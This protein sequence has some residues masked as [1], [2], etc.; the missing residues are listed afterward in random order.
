MA[1]SCGQTLSEGNVSAFAKTSGQ[2]ALVLDL[3]LDLVLEL[4]LVLDLVLELALVLD[5]VLELALAAGERCGVLHGGVMGTAGGS[6]T[7]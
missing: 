2:N 3:V 5:L 4:A 6:C 7:T 1:P